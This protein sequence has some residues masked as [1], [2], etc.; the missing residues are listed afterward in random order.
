MAC[1]NIWNTDGI[2]QIKIFK[3]KTGI[4]GQMHTSKYSLKLESSLGEPGKWYQLKLFAFTF[5]VIGLP[6]VWIIH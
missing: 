5:P 2:I 3:K 1:S 6:D 4:N